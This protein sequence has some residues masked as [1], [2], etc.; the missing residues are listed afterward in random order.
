MAEA[1]IGEHQLALGAALNIK[2]LDTILS[3]LSLFPKSKWRS[4]GL[5]AGLYHP[6][7]SD[8]KADHP[9]DVGGCFREC[10]SLWLRKK[11]GVDEKGIPTWLR[12]GDILE[13]I[14]EK[15]LADEIRKLHVD[16]TTKPVYV[17]P[18]GLKEE[19]SEI[20]DRFSFVLN[21][22]AEEVIKAN[23]LDKF[24][25]F[26]LGRSFNQPEGKEDVMKVRNE[27]DLVSLL[28]KYFFLSNFGAIVSF[29]EKYNLDSS[30][31]EL[32]K[33]SKEIDKLYSKILA[34]DF[35]QQAIED[36]ERKDY[37]GEM[38]FKVVWDLDT[39]LE[40]FQKFLADAFH[41]QGILIS[42]RVVQQSLFAFVCTIPKWLVE[43]MKEY[44][45]KN[46]KMLKS[47]K[48]VE[49]IIDGN[50]MFSVKSKTNVT[51]EGVAGKL[52]GLTVSEQGLF[53]RTETAAI[54]SLDPLSDTQ[55][56]EGRKHSL[57]NIKEHLIFGPHQSLF[58]ELEDIVHPDHFI[59][60]FKNF[61]STNVEYEEF[62]DKVQFYQHGI[63]K[64]YRNTLWN[65]E[66]YAEV[67]KFCNLFLKASLCC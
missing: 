47:K 59:Y 48:V 49:L 29:A 31:K 32:S 25:A 35:A 65:C 52:S 51:P 6:T 36:H 18:Y 13:E 60:Y 19:Y 34:K 38:I 1:L 61:I 8:I 14:G 55:I 50:V 40:K 30:K 15:D 20:N 9:G 16:G 24:K 42:L 22:F 10:V 54:E 39:A 4:F 5:K 46:K 17:V 11:D 41:S 66:S 21:D 7:L 62:T 53:R 43:E 33:F 57:V 28:Q 23:L 12:L 64:M 26:L 2:D 3:K 58:D 45:T 67:K 56:I 63:F 27:L 37:H 44:V